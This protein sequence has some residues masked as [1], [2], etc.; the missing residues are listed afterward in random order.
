MEKG[1]AMSRQSYPAHFY[2]DGCDSHPTLVEVCGG[3]VYELG[4]E[5]PKRIEHYRGKFVRLIEVAEPSHEEQRG[6]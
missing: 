4:Y 3:Y 2:P 5:R 1:K 6:V